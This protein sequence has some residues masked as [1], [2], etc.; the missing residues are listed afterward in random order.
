MEALVK[1]EN[2][3]TV[4]DSRSVAEYF[5]KKHKDVLVAI[6]NLAAKNPAT[7]LLFHKTTYISEQNGHSYPMYLMNRDGFSLLVMGFTGAKALE[8]KLEYIQAFNA[9]VQHKT[10]DSQLYPKA[11]EKGDRNMSD[12]KIFENP[13]FGK[14]RTIVIDDE[15]WFVGKDVAAALGYAD[16]KH[17]VRDHVDNDDKKMGGQNTPPYIEDSMGRK[18]YPVFINESGLYSLVL[19]SKL[20]TAKKFKHW[21]TNEVLPSIRKNGGYI[22]GQDTLSDNELMARALLLA[23]HVID[24]KNKQ[25]T[26]MKPK[27]EFYDTVANTESL[28]SMADVA[29]TL[30]MGMGRNKLFA[31]LRDKG[32]LDKDNHPYQKYVDAG[33]LRL[34]E[35][36]CKAGDN[37]VVYKCTYVKQRGIDYIRKILL[38]ERGLDENMG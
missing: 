6:K 20:P 8:R 3:Q 27:A 26:E 25:I 19:S 36:H 24:D 9:C 16:L 23:Q 15:P 4:T 1:V 22:A 17:A 31:F 18:Q 11:T 7:K 37:D 5:E 32:I 38:K 28:F 10:E 30:D 14:V 2:N 35:N 34:I 33:Y 13:E 21:V 12:I 29:K